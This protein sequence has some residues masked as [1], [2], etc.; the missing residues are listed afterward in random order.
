[1]PPG[2]AGRRPKPNAG[3]AKANEAA[4][5]R[6]RG[7]AALRKA[8]GGGVAARASLQPFAA[9]G[10]A[11]DGPAIDGPV[12]ADA[13]VSEAPPTAAVPLSILLTTRAAQTPNAR[14]TAMMA[15][16]GTLQR[17]A[18]RRCSAATAPPVSVCDLT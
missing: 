15:A 17:P 1:M 12:C 18:S 16:T 2:N 8:A 4:D 3:K 11:I 5:P 13:T 10:P 6:F 14:T 7:S 9:A